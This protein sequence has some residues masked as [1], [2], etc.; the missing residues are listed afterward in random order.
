M[1]LSFDLC[2]ATRTSRAFY[3]SLR[4]GRSR[5]WPRALLVASLALG[6]VC[7]SCGT[8]SGTPAAPASVTVLPN[9]AQPFAGGGV[10]F[11][12]EVQN[13][14]SSGVT[15]QV[16]QTPG[17][18]PAVGTI[19]STGYYLAPSVPPASGAVTVTAALQ[20]DPSVSGSASVAIQTTLTVT[21]AQ[22]ALTLSQSLQLQVINPGVS[23]GDVA[24][25]ATGGTIFAGSYTPPGV[26]GTYTITA[27]L[28]T[29]HNVAGH[30]TV[31]VTDF[32][33]TLTWRNDNARSG[34]NSRELALSP[35]TVNTTTF[36]RLFPCMVDGYIYAEPLYVANLPIGGGTRNVV[37][38]VTEND[39]VY[40]F[41]ADANPC[42]QLWMTSL[43][44]AGEQII[45]GPPGADMNLISNLGVTGTPAIGMAG[46]V[47]Y[48]YVVGATQDDGTS[49][50]NP[51]YHHRL[52]ALNLQKTQPEM[53]PAEVAIGTLA[54]E[55]PA[56]SSNVENQ[57][58]AL[59]LDGG[60]VYVA[61][62]SNGLP[63]DYHGWLFGYDTASLQ[64]TGN[65]T[66]TRSPD[67]Q[68]GIWQSAGGP[69]ADFNHNVFVATGDGPPNYGT[70][71]SDSFVRLE[72]S[73][74]W[75]VTDYFTPCDQGSGWPAGPNVALQSMSSAPLLSDSAGTTAQPHLLIGGSKEGFL[76]VV[77]RDDMGQFLPSPCPDSP[78]RVQSIPVGG[79]ILSTPLYW[80]NSVYVGP[81][82][83]HLM[84]LPMTQ[85]TL[86]PLPPASQSQETLGPLGATPVVSANGT[87]NAVLWLIDTSGAMAAP[88][89]PAVLRA[90]D[91]S[92][93]SNELY[94]SGMD[95]HDQAGL[96]VKFTVPTVANGKVYVGTQGE[97]DVYG[98]CRA[99]R[100]TP[101]SCRD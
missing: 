67:F 51:A 94:D 82:R 13:A 75:A 48:L 19:D 92:D 16:N 76:Y 65:F 81:G 18:N 34:V 66:P 50:S 61:F 9:S 28:N 30:A 64:P 88:N 70:D 62:G 53:Q 83:E 71:Y 26:A 29:N 86:S 73:G 45:Q 20:A 39:S 96:A 63:G 89:G 57:R 100:V 4:R 52:Y 72:T 11:S 38:V 36:G 95:P 98:L 87:S 79:P 35:L 7:V 12:A 99:A 44:P 25:A 85:G 15:W 17:G 1:P 37:F 6:T 78:K 101:A 42:Q 10:Q 80:N 22:A 33:G 49:S 21:P 59:L 27:S 31:Y 24:W 2:N 60:T 46:T 40:A 32:P 97:L 84:S 77:N 5:K 68:G 58:A 91:P 23:P 90:Y 55:S 56:F 74:Q 47:P 93:L 43:I 69:S 41:D 54:G 14:A 8:G 3:L